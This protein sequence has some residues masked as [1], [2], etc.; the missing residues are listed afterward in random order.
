MFLE[1]KVVQKLKLEKNVFTLLVPVCAA[2]SAAF[3]FPDTSKS[4]FTVGDQQILY[5]KMQISII[6]FIQIDMDA[7]PGVSGMSKNQ[8]FFYK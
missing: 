4:P 6:I 5:K 8:I 3:V 2:V 1:N 7:P